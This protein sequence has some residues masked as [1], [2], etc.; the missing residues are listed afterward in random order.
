MGKFYIFLLKYSRF[1][2]LISFFYIKVKYE[3]V[4]VDNGSE[5]GVV[6][7]ILQVFVVNRVINWS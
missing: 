2:S 5:D 7:S 4:L 3:I 1:R 6:E